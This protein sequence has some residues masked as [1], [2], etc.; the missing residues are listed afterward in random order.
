[1]FCR[2]II[3]LASDIPIDEPAE[4]AAADSIL[5]ADGSFMQ[6]HHCASWDIVIFVNTTFDE[7]LQRGIARD[8]EQF[9]DHAAA[10]QRYTHRYHS[11]ARMYIDD[12]NPIQAADFVID[13]DDPSNPQLHRTSG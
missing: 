10:E 5:I 3:D 4:L 1:M 2:R 8:A 9:G 12:V 11:A 13:N 6:R 7:A